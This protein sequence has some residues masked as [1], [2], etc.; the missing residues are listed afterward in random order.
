[1]TD[2]FFRNNNKKKEEDR[3]FRKYIDNN[4]NNARKWELNKIPVLDHTT[5]G[6]KLSDKTIFIKNIIKNLDIQDM[7]LDFNYESHLNILNT[8][9][10]KNKKEEIFDYDYII[11]NNITKI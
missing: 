4:F 1:M 8:W 3:I 7:K 6:M 10:N 5:K 2:N 9:V 11:K